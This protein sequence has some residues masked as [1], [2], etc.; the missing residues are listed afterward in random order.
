[1]S[2]TA[3]Q[4]AQKGST[5]R[6][7]TEPTSQAAPNKTDAPTEKKGF[8]KSKGFFRRLRVCPFAGDE[9]PIDYKNVKL[10]RQFITERGK[11]MPRRLTFVSAKRQR[12]LSRAIKRARF[13]ALLPYTT[14]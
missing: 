2:F 1:M 8:I 6:E 4:D 11:I 3:H 5:A 12:E 14:D 9:T 7:A 10:L 13:L